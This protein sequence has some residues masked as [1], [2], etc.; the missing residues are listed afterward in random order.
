VSSFTRAI[1]GQPFRMRRSADEDR[2]LRRKVLRDFIGLFDRSRDKEPK[3]RKPVPPADGVHDHTCSKNGSV[4]P[5]PILPCA[6][7]QK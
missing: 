2:G 1:E 6:G 7:L 3:S 4:M 5:L